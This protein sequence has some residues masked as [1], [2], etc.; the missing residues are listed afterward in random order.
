MSAKTKSTP[1]TEGHVA[2]IRLLAR[3]G[4][5]FYLQQEKEAPRELRHL[6]PV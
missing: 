6:R 4:V 1:L 5:A 3:Q 2:I